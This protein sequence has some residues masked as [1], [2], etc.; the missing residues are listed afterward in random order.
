MQPLLI[1]R[2]AFNFTIELYNWTNLL[3]TYTLV[4]LGISGYNKGE[5]N[6]WI[7]IINLVV[8]YG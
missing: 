6:S 7:V 8:S 4:D 5:V 2:V 1:K 3:L